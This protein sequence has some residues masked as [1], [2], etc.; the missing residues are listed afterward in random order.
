LYEKTTVKMQHIWQKK[1]SDIKEHKSEIFQYNPW[2]NMSMVQW[3]I[4][5]AAEVSMV[6]SDPDRSQIHSSEIN[7]IIT[8]VLK[9]LPSVTIIM[10]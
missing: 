3:Q 5:L 10:Q 2:C 7:I 8:G 9:I 4:Q 1:T 6:T